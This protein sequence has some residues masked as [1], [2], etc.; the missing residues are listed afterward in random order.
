MVSTAPGEQ[1][2]KRQKELSFQMTYV[3]QTDPVVSTGWS[4]FYPTNLNE[5]RHR[6]GHA[7]KQKPALKKLAFSGAHMAIMQKPPS[8]IFFTFPSKASDFQIVGMQ[9]QLATAKPSTR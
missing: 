5:R 8:G 1:P 4:V 6:R 9:W 2:T 7:R 3:W